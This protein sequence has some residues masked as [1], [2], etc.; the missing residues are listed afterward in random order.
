[1]ASGHS[2]GRAVTGDT[3]S[4]EMDGLRG[5]K[6]L[7]EDLSGLLYPTPVRASTTLEE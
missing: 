6:R 4:V 3:V 7:S 5:Q 2:W 1:M